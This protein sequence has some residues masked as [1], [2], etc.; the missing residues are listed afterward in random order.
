[1]IGGLLMLSCVGRPL[2]AQRHSALEVGFT[3]VQF[4]DDSSV[5]LGPSVGWTSA[6][7]RGGLFGEITAGGIGTFGAATGSASAVG[8]ARA[9]LV[10]GIVV[11]TAG[12]LFGIAGS[13]TRSAGTASASGRVIHAS[14][15]TGI[16]AG[17]SAAMSR[18]EA[19]NMPAAALEGG[20]W[21]GGPRARVSALLTE[22]R[23]TGQLFV[24]EQRQYLIGTVPVRYAEA[25]VVLHLE[26]DLASLDVSGG[27]RRDPD[28]ASLFE[29]TFSATAAVWRSSS[30]ALTFSVSHQ[31]ADFVR[32]ADAAR[33][34]AI[35]MRFFQRP[36]A[37]IR[38]ERASPIVE[39]IGVGDARVVRVRVA[40]ARRVELM[41]DFTDWQPIALTRGATGFEGSAPVAAGSHRVLV[42]IDG[43][44]W[45]PAANTPAVNDD[46]GGRVG[47]LVVP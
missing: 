20:A 31:P 16:W 28:A 10:R 4:S 35:G 19:G 18:R 7:D 3:A 21:V 44:E 38:A 36:P 11:E 17:G 37:S 8:G 42:R 26:N 41:A 46:L 9:A 24:G 45:R 5:V 25:S 43:A 30:R 47:L 22:Q 13:S 40:D 33:S 6:V 39:V 2:G 34:I 23:A 15:R 12:E 14:G 32:G 27:A 1:M 29:P